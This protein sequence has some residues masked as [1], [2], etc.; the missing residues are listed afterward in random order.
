MKKLYVASAM[1]ALLA[2]ATSCDKYDIYPEQYGKVLMI[3]DA[4]ERSVTIYA[5]EETAPYY[6]SVMKNGHTPEDPAQATLKVLNDAEF[7]EYKE[8]YY[9]SKDFAG[10]VPLKPEF[11]YLATPDTIATDGNLID[12]TFMTADDRY[13][14]A[15]VVFNAQAISDWRADLESRA[16]EANRTKNPEEWA[17][18]ND[19]INNYTF[20][21]PIGLYSTN[22]NDSINS[23]N[24]YLM[25]TPVVENPVVNVNVSNDA[26]FLTDQN[27]SMLKD[28]TSDY[29]NG[30][31][32]PEI[33][34]SIPCPNPYGFEVKYKNNPDTDIERFNQHHKDMVL[35]RLSLKN[36]EGEY[37]YVNSDKA[38]TITFPAGVTEVRLP[39]SFPRK[40]MNYNDM[41]NNWVTSIQLSS[42]SWPDKTTPAKIKSSLKLPQSELTWTD[43]SG[44]TQRYD[45][46]TF[47]VG[48]RV[49]EEPMEL[50][51]GCV[52]GANDPELTEGSFAAMFDDDLSTFYHSAWSA[53]S[54][55]ERQ[56]P[57]G[58]YIDFEMPTKEPINAIAIKFTARVH[59]NPHSP[60]LVS[61]FYSNEVNEAERNANWKEIVIEK[62]VPGVGKN[63]AASG[64]VT[65]LGGIKNDSEWIKSPEPF[66][67]LRMSVVK[68]NLDE[69]LYTIGSAAAGY[70]NVA[71]IRMYGTVID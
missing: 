12:H 30:A 65:W 36:S 44:N 60:K 54:L 28:E 57:Y 1:V 31:Y 39:Y 55:R 17:L 4:G 29:R 25:L 49:V 34:F 41:E 35:T 56:K 6:V 70:W 27:R 71:E 23:E 58:S 51:E 62:E 64:Q 38:A 16:K 11:Y 59:S 53:N 5:T 14:G 33:I 40:Q 47:F 22:K 45:G 68:N 7:G 42:I 32:E 24:R 21:A 26:V 9:G 15:L 52:L 43:G 8:K 63:Q 20:V 67:Y 69:N 18:A 3:K 46:Y 48:Y 13:F 61:L 19:T 37:N 2:A 50:D 10:L 66:R